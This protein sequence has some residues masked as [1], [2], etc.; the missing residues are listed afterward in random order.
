MLTVKCGPTEETEQ[1]GTLR[2]IPYTT[3]KPWIEICRITSQFGTSTPVLGSGAIVGDSFVLTAAHVVYASGAPA[4]SCIVQSGIDPSTGRA[5]LVA[6][7]TGAADIWVPDQYK[8]TQDSR[9]DIACIHLNDRIGSKVGFF[10][11]SNWDDR[12]LMNA[13][14][15][16]AGYPGAIPTGTSPQLTYRQVS[17]TEFGVAY[18]KY[19]GSDLVDG[20]SGG[21]IY[22]AA[23]GREDQFPDWP[24]FI[25]GVHT[26][27][28]NGF[29]QAT[30]ITRDLSVKIQSFMHSPQFT[31]G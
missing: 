13:E 12:L 9:F 2:S 5:K 27:L 8:Q 7:T 31:N 30:R 22:V 17:L 4:N 16:F 15:H 1:V 21:P 3:V 11:F 23:Q 29:G 10:Q 6:S 18:L 14:L 20:D 26:S 19:P 24:R 25:V 28:N